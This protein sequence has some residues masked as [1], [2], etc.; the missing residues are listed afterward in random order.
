VR[1]QGRVELHVIGAPES[2]KARLQPLADAGVK[3]RYHP[4]VPFNELKEVFQRLR[5]DVGVV[6]LDEASAGLLSPSKFSAYLKFGLPVLYIG[7]KK[8]NTDVICTRFGGGWRLPNGAN[9]SDIASAAARIWDA[10]AWPTVRKNLEQ[11][12]RYFGAFNEH[13]LA[14]AL[15]PCLKRLAQPGSNQP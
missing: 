2:A 9:A 5:L 6:I 13:S 4:R 10:P 11:A 7:P 15:V 12:A 14:E 8:T 1:A 3:V